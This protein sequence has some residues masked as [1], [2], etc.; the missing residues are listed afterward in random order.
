[1]WV[2]TYAP[3]PTKGWVASGTSL[4][5]NPR[6]SLGRL[7]GGGLPLV[8]R[9]PGGVKGVNGPWEFNGRVYSALLLVTGD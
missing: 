1:M 2:S 9:F 8:L 3:D 7:R 4:M 5:L 6:G